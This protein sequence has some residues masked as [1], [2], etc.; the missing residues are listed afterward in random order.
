M[1]WGLV[2]S[3]IRLFLAL[4]CRCTRSH[5]SN[6][7]V[8]CH[9]SNLSVLANSVLSI[10]GKFEQQSCVQWGDFA[11]GGAGFTDC[12][13]CS[14]RHK[15]YFTGKL[16]FEAVLGYTWWYLECLLLTDAQGTPDGAQGSL[17]CIRDQTW[18]RYM[19][20]KCPT[21]CTISQPR[22]MSLESQNKYY[23]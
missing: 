14:R 8:F 1:T 6:W 17:C 18:V 9:G 19:Q 10:T 3:T 15:T 20:N 23:T 7:G 22:K 5:C 4:C 11:E 16:N 2:E 21:S 12:H 13:C